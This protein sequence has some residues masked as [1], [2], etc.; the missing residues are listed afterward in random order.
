MRLT[1]VETAV[2][3]T[4]VGAAASFSSAWFVQRATLARERESRV[5]ERRAAVYEEAL[6][7]VKRGERFRADVLETGALPE[8]PEQRRSE[9]QADLVLAR[10]EIYGSPRLVEA[11]RRTA[12]EMRQWVRDFASWKEQ[13]TQGRTPVRS[14][15][16]PLWAAVTLQAD[17]ARVVDLEFTGLVQADIQA[18]RPGRRSPRIRISWRRRLP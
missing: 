14:P 1:P 6:T 16:D 18:Q 9:V 8:I 17:R 7:S 10:L 15:A 5:W 12:A 2:I 13:A 11:H 3:G 4:A